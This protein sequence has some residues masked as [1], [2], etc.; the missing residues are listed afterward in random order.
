MFDFN[1]WI[2]K[3][4]GSQKLIKSK[5]ENLEIYT[6]FILTQGVFLLLLFSNYKLKSF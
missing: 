1:W 6:K 5:F 3:N 2:V 4:K